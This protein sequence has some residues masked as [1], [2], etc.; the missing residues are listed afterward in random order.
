[1]NP[2]SHRARIF[3]LELTVFVSMLGVG[4]IVPFLP[5]YARD[6]G[7]SA[8]TMGA[9]FSSFSLARGLVMPY[10]GS[11][12]DRHG[13]KIFI[14]IGLLG[15]AL[16]ALALIWA[17]SPWEL[18]L[19]RVLQGIFA[20]MVLPV[21]MA[22]VADMTPEGQ[23]GSIFGGFNTYF[24]LG[25]AV[26]PLIGGATYDHLGLNSNFLLM[27]GLSLLSLLMVLFMV[28]EPKK[29]KQASGKGGWAEQLALLKDRPLLAVFLARSLSAAGMGCFVAFLPV[30]AAE[31]SLSNTELG[32][33]LAVNV[34][35][36]TGLQKPCGWLADR[37][38]RTGLAAMGLLLSGAC[39]GMLP[40]PG[41]FQGLLML[42]VLEG[43]A[44]GLALPS[45]TA[46]AVSNGR[47]VGAGMGVTMGSF[48]MAMSLGVSIGPLAAGL[49]A[50]W[51]GIDMVFYM[52]GGATILGAFCLFLPDK[53][54]EPVEPPMT[55]HVD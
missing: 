9:I 32:W 5:L 20:A 45:L 21:S 49:L 12:S 23:E 7:A 1:M 36:M 14:I 31:K 37:W 6:M 11:L 33:L 27:A 55:R 38:S 41:D 17:S 46:L 43:V 13:R 48:G 29:V 16:L 25:F 35:V 30:L 2:A 51:R 22:L 24:L 3:I 8:F 42:C 4:I 40:L 44:A 34:L 26:G 15:Y 10:V 52:A 19:N 47:R 53:P 18:V 50:D 54:A 39:K 28:K